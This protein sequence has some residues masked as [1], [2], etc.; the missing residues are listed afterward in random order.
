MLLSSWGPMLSLFAFLFLVIAMFAVF[1][2]QLFGGHYNNFN[3]G[4]PRSNFDTFPQAWLTIFQVTS[5]DQWISITYEAMRLQWV[6]LHPPPPDT[7]LPIEQSGWDQ[8]QL[9]SLPGRMSRRPSS[10]SFPLLSPSYPHQR[11]QRP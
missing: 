7:R 11:S 8:R 9:E 4:H 5:S 6:S 10:P 3:D 2:M 1:A